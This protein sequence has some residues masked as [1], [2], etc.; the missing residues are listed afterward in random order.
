MILPVGLADSVFNY[1]PGDF[2]IFLVGQLDFVVTE[3][4]G[5]GIAS[6]FAETVIVNADNSQLERIGSTCSQRF[7]I[8]MYSARIWFA[9]RRA[10]VASW[11]LV[12]SSDA[13]EVSD[14]VVGSGTIEEGSGS[15]SYAS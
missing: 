6:L 7:S 4:L 1:T 3:I 15:G 11:S 12:I 5:V 10:I 8:Y 2:A 14:G 9:I 13:S